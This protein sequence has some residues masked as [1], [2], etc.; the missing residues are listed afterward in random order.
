MLVI[1][2]PGQGSQVPG[3]L[4]PWLEDP[5][6]AD[7]VGRLGEAADTDLTTH[8]TTSDADTIRDTSVAQPLIVAAGLV[9]LAAT[10]ES[11]DGS[12]PRPPA[13]ALSGHS[14]GEITAAAIAGALTPEQAMT[15]V[16]V[17]GRAMAEASRAHPTGM[18]AVLG[19]TM[20]DVV[21][22]I[23]RHGLTPA[24]VNGAGQIVAAGDLDALAAL[25]E[26]PPAKARVRPLQVAGAF[27]T[28]YMAS[29]V[30]AL[31]E[32]ARGMKVADPAIPLVS[33]RDGEIVAS[34]ADL[35]ARLVH[36]VSNPVRWDL[37][38]ERFGAM[39]VT[40][41]LELLPSGTLTGLAKRGLKG[42]E[43]F[44]VSGPDVLDD[45][46]AFVAAH[47]AEQSA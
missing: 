31:D 18:S 33:N 29:A 17:R 13:G 34:G 15:L 8:G 36:Q 14:V 47:A 28:T 24:N 43:L 39:G 9:S 23:E 38:M 25:G 44:G 37:C 16:G 40:G 1:V 26:D 27:H 30:D 11:T 21:A 42:V 7:L 41:I 12:L 2:C 45:A 5:G 19:G 32:A 6:L 10:F 35:V 46:R 22:A 20:D 3:L 4:A